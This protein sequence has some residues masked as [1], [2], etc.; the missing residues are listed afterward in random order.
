[1]AES[2]QVLRL[3]SRWQFLFTCVG[4]GLLFLFCALGAVAFMV[5]GD[6]R[7]GHDFGPFLMCVGVGLEGA[8]GLIGGLFAGARLDADGVTAY[9]YTHRPRRVPWGRI[10]SIRVGRVSVGKSSVRAPML[11]LTDGTTVPLTWV[12][13]TRADIVRAHRAEWEQANLNR[14]V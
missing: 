6:L 5:D 13:H 2:G 3:R 9:G 4:G 11:E 7:P 8:W 1:M 10:E 12:P 14:P